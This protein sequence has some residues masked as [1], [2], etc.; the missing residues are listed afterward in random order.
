MLDYNEINV[1]FTLQ[2]ELITDSTKK[3]TAPEQ[4]LPQTTAPLGSH[5]L[6]W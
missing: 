5:N 3:Q 6:F 2:S 4:I 1:R